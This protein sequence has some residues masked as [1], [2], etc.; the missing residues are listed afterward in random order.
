MLINV[1]LLPLFIWQQGS[2]FDKHLVQ[3]MIACIVNNV[4]TNEHWKVIF[5]M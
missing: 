3:F 4:R 2:N 1:A 5:P